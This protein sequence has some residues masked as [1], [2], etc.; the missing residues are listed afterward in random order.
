MSSRFNF[1]FMGRRKYMFGFSAILLAISIGALLIQGLT[2]SIEF[3]GG[4]A[5]SIVDAGDVS[6]EEIRSAFQDE[7][8]R[9]SC[10][11]R[12]YI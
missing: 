9:A 7:I 5:V 8:G 11:E 2:F 1:D 12:V 10:R 4:T 6:I 3:Q